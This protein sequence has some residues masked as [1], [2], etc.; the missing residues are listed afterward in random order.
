LLFWN[1]LVTRDGFFLN[2]DIT[3]CFQ[4]QCIL[5][6]VFCSKVFELLRGKKS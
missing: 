6:T 5:P 4:S 2:S 3:I 1:R